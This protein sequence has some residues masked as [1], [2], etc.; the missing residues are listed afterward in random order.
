MTP[1]VVLHYCLVYLP[2]SEVFIYRQIKFAN[3]VDSIVVARESANTDLFPWKD[4]SI[5]HS[6]ISGPFFIPKVLLGLDTFWKFCYDIVKTRKVA[7]L[8]AHFGHL[9]YQMLRLR[10]RTGLPLVTSFYG[11]DVSAIARKRRWQRNYRILFEEGDVFMVEGNHLKN[12]LV[13]LRCPEEKIR[14]QHLGVELDQVPFISRVP[15]DDSKVVILFCGRFIQKKG[16]ID[17][18]R[19]VREGHRCYPDLEFRLIGDGEKRPQVEEFIK[20]NGM[21]SY[22][23]L[24]GMQPYSVVREELEKADIFIHPSL[25]AGDGETEGGAPTILLDAQASGLPV[26]STLHCDIPEY[27]LDG[28]SGFLVQEKDWEALS[29]RLIYLLKNQ[30]I[31]E[32]MGK[33]GRKHIEDHYDIKKESV[34][35]T[36]ENLAKYDCVL[37]STDHS[38]Y[39]WD[40]IGKNSKLVVDTRNAMLD[41]KDKKNIVNTAEHINKSK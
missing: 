9:G 24:L 11:M 30:D 37:I 4:V 20:T 26:L 13:A 8:H 18:L 27:V 1:C 34:E 38:V 32:K 35:L 29:D 33:A 3:G 19:A 41:V 12:S 31:W 10:R 40:F 7:V 22:V 23:R 28:K 5:H 2:I 15:K 39:D 14:I 17:A 21:E 36:P 16:L 6:N 25:T